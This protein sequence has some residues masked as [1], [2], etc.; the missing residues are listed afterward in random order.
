MNDYASRVSRSGLGMADEF[1]KIKE[2]LLGRLERSVR[3]TLLHLAIKSWA[4]MA[5]WQ[6][7]RIFPE[8]AWG[9]STRKTGAAAMKS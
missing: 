2:M 8:S 6:I 4:V 1:A 5:A 3:S 9:F 7:Q